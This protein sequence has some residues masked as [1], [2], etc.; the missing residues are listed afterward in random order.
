MGLFENAVNTAR[1][2]AKTVG[3]KAEEVLDLSRNK[4]SIS[5]LENKLEAS[6]ASLG[7]LYYNY[8]ENGTTDP[9]KE[10]A[11]VREI[12]GIH[13]AVRELKENINEM[14]NRVTCPACAAANDPQAVFCSQCGARLQGEE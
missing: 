6:Y 9:E 14:R 1:S 5:E 4:L 3:K 11:L 13:A 10:Q 7:M 8:L 12:D 2:A